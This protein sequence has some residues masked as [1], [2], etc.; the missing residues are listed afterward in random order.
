MLAKCR[1]AAG[2]ASGGRDS[3]AGPRRAWAAGAVAASRE[4][5]PPRLLFVGGAS[6]RDLVHVLVEQRALLETALE[7]L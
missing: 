3:R 1:G 6:R 5:D 4:G 2:A 7:L